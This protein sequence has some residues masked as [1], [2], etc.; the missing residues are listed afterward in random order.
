MG[1]SGLS[2]QRHLACLEGTSIQRQNRRQASPRIRFSRLVG[3]IIKI[4]IEG[5]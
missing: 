5:P 4:R 2:K 1:L 3:S